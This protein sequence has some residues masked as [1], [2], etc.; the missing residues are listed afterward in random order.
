VASLPV[1]SLPDPDRELLN[2]KGAAVDLARLAELVDPYG[3]EIQKQTAGLVLESALL[4]FMNGLEGQ[5]G[6]R[7]RR[8]KFVD[9]AMF[10][11]H[12][13]RGWKLILGIKRK[14]RVAWINCRRYVRFVLLAVCSFF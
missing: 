14:E 2:P 13:P 6:S 4:G 11:D 3:E 12:L 7:R 9:A 8:R 5:W 10:G 1:P